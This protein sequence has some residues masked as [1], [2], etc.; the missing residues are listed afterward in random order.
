M[1]FSNDNKYIAQQHIS[2]NEI[3]KKVKLKATNLEGQL[4]KNTTI[5]LARFFLYLAELHAERRQESLVN[6]VLNRSLTYSDLEEVDLDHDK[7]VRS[8]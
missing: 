8:A 2:R 3:R 1:K 7:V 5:C 6:W 4:E